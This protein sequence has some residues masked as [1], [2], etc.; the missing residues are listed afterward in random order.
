MLIIALDATCWSMLELDHN[1]LN[2]LQIRFPKSM[3]DTWRPRN[4][5]IPCEFDGLQIFPLAIDYD[6]IIATS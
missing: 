4:Y 3:C 5:A 6:H 1:T 2:L